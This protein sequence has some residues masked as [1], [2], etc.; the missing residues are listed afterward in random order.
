MARSAPDLARV[1]A[2]IAGVW[3]V[4]WLTPQ[5]FLEIL[6][7]ALSVFAA[8]MQLR[9]P[10]RGAYLP[11]APLARAAEQYAGSYS[12]VSAPARDLIEE[13]LWQGRVLVAVVE[14][15]CGVFDKE[16][17]AVEAG[18]PG[19]DPCSGGF[20]L[21]LTPRLER[22]FACRSAHWIFQKRF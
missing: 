5:S 21:P 22:M 20:R 11:R 13:K 19:R 14:Q 2:P 18:V 8:E 6:S 3:F 4:S 15:T 17:A 16:I 10:E 12:H 9:L 7:K 1:A